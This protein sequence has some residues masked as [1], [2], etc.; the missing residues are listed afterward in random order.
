MALALHGQ[1]ELSWSQVHDIIELL[2]GVDRIARAGR[3]NR[4]QLRLVRKTADHYRHLGDPERYPLADN[5]PTLDE[6]TVLVRDVL[7][8]YISSRL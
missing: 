8:R 6:A 7:K 3:G 5:P 4:N 2:D 1:G